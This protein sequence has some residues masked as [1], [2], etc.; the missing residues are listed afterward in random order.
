MKEYPVLDQVLLVSVVLLILFGRYLLNS[1]KLIF[2]LLWSFL[3]WKKMGVFFSVIFLFCKIFGTCMFTPFIF[4][5]KLLVSLRQSMLK[6]KTWTMSFLDLL[7]IQKLINRIEIKK[8]LIY[9]N[10]TWKIYWILLICF[11]Y[12]FFFFE[13][14][15][16]FLLSIMMA[17][18]FIW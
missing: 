5:C 11:C 12:T 7:S 14:S 15:T 4:F 9:F 8:F 18:Y 16:G 17:N 13:T 3:K 2:R 10:I 1:L 6:L